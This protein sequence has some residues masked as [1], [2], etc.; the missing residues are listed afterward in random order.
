M[1]SLMNRMVWNVAM[2]S[3]LALVCVAGPV[4][5][6]GDKAAKAEA[7]AANKEAKAAAKS[8]GKAKTVGGEIGEMVKELNLTQQQQEAL[9][10]N[11]KAM[12]DALKTF[13]ASH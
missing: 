2:V 12:S 6:Q 11:Q 7:R 8:E 13:E 10:P 9:V 1:E 4:W 5:A 3:A